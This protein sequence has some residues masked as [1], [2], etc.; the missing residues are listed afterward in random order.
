MH[1]QFDNLNLFLKLQRRHFIQIQISLALKQTMHLANVVLVLINIR[2]LTHTTS[3]KSL[4][5]LISWQKVAVNLLIPCLCHLLR[6]HAEIPDSLRKNTLPRQGHWRAQQAEQQKTQ[7]HWRQY[8]STFMYL[9]YF[10][11]LHASLCVYGCLLQSNI[12]KRYKIGCLIKYD[13][14][15]IVGI[16]ARLKP[17]KPKGCCGLNNKNNYRPI[18]MPAGRVILLISQSRTATCRQ[19]FPPKKNQKAQYNTPNRRNQEVGQLL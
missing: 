10:L 15:S 4:I 17:G 1:C 8:L 19:G 7:T 16:G 6:A 14:S 12:Q 2:N 5:H 18:P 9:L 3:K 11:L 13:K